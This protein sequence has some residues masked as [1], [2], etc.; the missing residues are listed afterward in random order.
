[1]CLPLAAAHM[2]PLHHLMP[3][4]GQ[5]PV[6]LTLCRIQDWQQLHHD[7]VGGLIASLCDCLPPSCS[8]AVLGVPS[9]APA[10]CRLSCNASWVAH[11]CIS[12]PSTLL[13]AASVLPTEAGC[14]VTLQGPLLTRV[15]AVQVTA[16][17]RGVSVSASAACVND[18]QPLL[19]TYRCD[20]MVAAAFACNVSLLFLTRDAL[21]C[22][23]GRPCGVLLCMALACAGCQPLT[24]GNEPCLRHPLVP[25]S[26]RMSLACQEEQR[27]QWPAGAPFKPLS[28][29]QLV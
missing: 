29:V 28:S 21:Q 7:R 5:R 25:C 9:K 18:E 23:K 14:Q 2:L 17:T 15:A 26:I 6:W 1:M 4:S 12:G 20:P 13:L 10:C 24:P 19:F 16:V 22:F 8:A 11:L 3:F 27:G